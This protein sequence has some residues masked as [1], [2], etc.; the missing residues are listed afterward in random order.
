MKDNIKLKVK[1]NVERT[2]IHKPHTRNSDIQ[3]IMNVLRDM[4]YDILINGPVEGMPSF[5][6]ITRVRRKFNEVGLFLPTDPDVLSQ[7]R[8]AEDEMRYINNWF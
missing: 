5:G 2:L 8:K 3:L 7:R 6:S 4:G 1:D